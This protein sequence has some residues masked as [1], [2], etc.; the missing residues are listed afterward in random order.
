MD[1]SDL[2]NMDNLRLL[3]Y[4]VT[5]QEWAWFESGAC[6]A[7]Q[8]AAARRRG[9]SP[10]LAPLGRAPPTSRGC[11]LAACNAPIPPHTACRQ[12]G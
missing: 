4:Y 10:A 8:P 2:A 6:G 9:A 12:D 3:K 11:T 1:V 7:E 5:P